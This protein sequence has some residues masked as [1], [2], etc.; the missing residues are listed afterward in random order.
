MKIKYKEIES[1]TEYG[2]VIID[3]S[4]GDIQCWFEAGSSYDWGLRDNE[5]E[6]L[7]DSLP[8]K[9]QQNFY[10]KFWDMFDEL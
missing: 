4:I 2:Y 9:E 1:I 5:D 8:D 3:T 10:N 7:F 6:E